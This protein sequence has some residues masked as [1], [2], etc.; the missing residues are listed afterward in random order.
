MEPPCHSDDEYE[1]MAH[2]ERPTQ[3]VTEFKPHRP[4][5]L[6]LHSRHTKSLSLPYMKSPVDGPVENSSSDDEVSEDDGDGENYSSEEDESMFVKSLPSD[7]FLNTLSG[8]ETDAEDF[9]SPDRDLL[10]SL[11]GEEERSYQPLDVELPVCMEPTER[12][13]EKAGND[14]ERQETKEMEENEVHHEDQL[15]M[16]TER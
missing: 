7:F 9:P 5:S 16:D 14:E 6:D 3:S 15:E 8:L 13:Q 1:M 12:V 2:A 11:R 10:D 4:L